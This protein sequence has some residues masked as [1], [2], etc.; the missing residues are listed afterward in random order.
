MMISHTHPA[1]K[2]SLTE[3]RVSQSHPCP[4]CGKPDWCI[5]DG[6]GHVICQ[7]IESDRPWGEAGWF[8]ELNQRS[9]A[10]GKSNRPRTPKKKSFRIHP[11]K[12]KGDPAAIYYYNH[13]DGS[14]C[15]RKVRYNTSNG[16]ITPYQRYEPIADK[17]IGGPGCMEGVT[18][19]PYRYEPLIHRTGTVY[20]VEGEKCADLLWDFGLMATTS[21]GSSEWPPGFENYFKGKEQVIILPDNDAAGI[22]YALK[23]AEMIYRVGIDV[24]IVDLPGLKT[25]EDVYDWLMEGSL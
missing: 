24:K 10:H 2:N 13:A 25:K 21:G 19:V 22:K 11:W 12:P 23:A 3:Y 6:D 15:Y 1:F 5:S 14:P 18:R 7:R 20:L 8:H 4:I 16:K 17:W 9:Q